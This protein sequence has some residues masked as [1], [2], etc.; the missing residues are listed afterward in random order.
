MAR[1]KSIGAQLLTEAA[2]ASR[3]R[4]A[5][6]ERE[7]KAAAAQA[8]RQRDKA[9]K[10]ARQHEKDAAA[11]AAKAERDRAAVERNREREQRLR[12]RQANLDRKASRLAEVD[13]LNRDLARKRQGLESVLADRDRTFSGRQ[14]L[15]ERT[16]DA[17]GREAFDRLLL[18]SFGDSRSGDV[19]AG[20]ATAV[21]YRPEIRELIVECELPDRNVIPGATSY[22]YVASRDAI[23]PIAVKP[24]DVRAAYADLVARL[25]LRTARESLDIA[26]ASLVDTVS[27]NAYAEGIDRTTGAP[28]RPCV[29]SVVAERTTFDHLVLDQLDPIACLRMHL[30]AIVSPNPYDF[31]AVR[32]VMAFD[33]SRYRFVESQDVIA[34][35]DSRTDLL[36][37]KP[38]EF[39]YLIR[40]LVE[41]MGMN[42]W[43]TQ[44]SNDD[45]VDAVAVNPNPMVGGKCI[46]QA[47]RYS[48]VVSLESVHALAGNVEDHKAARGLLI[49]TSWVGAKSLAFAERHGRLEIWDG[50]HLKALIREHLGKDTLISLPVVPPGW[51]SADVA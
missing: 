41:A 7:Q 24:A 22:R 51:T 13:R 8:A 40:E 1:R 29:L 44:L 43:N 3:E 6:K 21:E 48:K 16:F 46:I 34:T 20:R 30:R 39:E 31:E 32:P 14:A 50:R 10:E 26:P 15:A 2:R 18:V 9:A 12:D 28:I 27:V 35:L 23:D 37:L 42:A 33:F 19:L 25:A 38:V 45:G 49:T 11:R 5:R 17:S 4:R 36:S 47:K